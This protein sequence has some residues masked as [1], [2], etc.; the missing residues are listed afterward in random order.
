MAEPLTPD[1]VLDAALSIVEQDG[2]DGLSMRALAAKL[3]VAVT[4]IYWHVGNKEQVLD[5]L[6]DRMGAEVGRIRTTGHTPAERVLSTARSLLRS[7]DAHRSLVGIAHGRGRLGVVFAPARRA[8]AETFAGA[9]LRGA[10]L[11]DATEAVVQVV[12]A[13][14]LTEAV[15]R[16]SPEQQAD[17][18]LWVGPAPVDDAAARRLGRPPDPAHT[19]DVSLRAL[20]RGLLEP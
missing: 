15:V 12:A 9:G 10:R 8:L 2:V 1:Q 20:V 18:T 5:A 16:R 7:I 13:F 3:G 4:A 19:F 11:A 14:S 17:V 6:V